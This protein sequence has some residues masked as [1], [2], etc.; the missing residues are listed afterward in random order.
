M[1]RAAALAW[2]LLFPNCQPSQEMLV[3]TTRRGLLLAAVMLSSASVFLAGCEEGAFEEAGEEVDEAVDEAA[4]ETE[5]AV[6]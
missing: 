5:D 6:Q 2:K 4:D 1:P 3:Q